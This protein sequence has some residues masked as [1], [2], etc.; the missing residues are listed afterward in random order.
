MRIKLR[1]YKPECSLVEFVHN[2][3][4]KSSFEE[5]LLFTQFNTFESAIKRCLAIE[6]T[7]ETIAERIDLPNI[8]N[9]LLDVPL[10]W[11][12]AINNNI[13]NLSIFPDNNLYNWLY[14]NGYNNIDIETL[15][16]STEKVEKLM[17]AIND[18]DYFKQNTKIEDSLI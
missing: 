14:E 6:K 13:Q 12:E 10:A 15:K 5:D 2:L 4:S 8:R 1:F 9:I 17:Q 11:V 18:L 16:P 7:F 3:Q